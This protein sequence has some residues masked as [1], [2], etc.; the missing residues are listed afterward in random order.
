MV[1][2]METQ[3]TNLKRLLGSPAADWVEKVSLYVFND[4]KDFVEF[5]RTVEHREVSAA[6]SASGNLAEPQPYVAVV[7]PLGGKKEDP[8]AARRKPRGKK[9][10]D[11]EAAG[12]T[13]RSLI[14][15][16]TEQLADSAVASQGKSPRWLAQGFGAFLSAQ[17]EPRSPYYQRLRQTA[18][19]KYDQG[20]PTKASD[21]LSESNEVS[22]KRSARWASRSWNR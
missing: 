9:T 22:V 3:Y 17:V 13:D 18:W 7:D 20:W 14:G 12:G 6:V 15:L 5:A 19:Q 10:D 16:L 11:K 1:K 8:S 2:A 21:A 4:R